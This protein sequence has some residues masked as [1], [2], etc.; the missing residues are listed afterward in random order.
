MLPEWI[1]YFVFRRGFFHGL[2]PF[3]L[4][5]AGFD[6][7][8]LW[9]A[10]SLGAP[11]IDASAVITVIHQNHDYSHHPEGQKGVW[12]GPEAV[13]NRELMGGLHHCFTLDDAS[14]KLV[15]TGI[16]LNLT[17]ERIIRAIWT[18]P[19]WYGLLV[20]IWNRMI[21]S[22]LSFRSR[23]G[24]TKLDIRRRWDVVKRAF[25]IFLKE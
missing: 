9:K 6:N 14:Y 18:R 21:V 5:R 17:K 10:R 7:W 4:G 20:R 13:R 25:N 23:L 12:E 16:K 24:L 3:A 8:L 11:V 22:T 19:L 1:D 2:L 15:L